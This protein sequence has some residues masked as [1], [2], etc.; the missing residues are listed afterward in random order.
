MT[1]DNEYLPPVNLLSDIQILERL[2]AEDPQCIFVS[3]LINPSVQVGPSSLDLRLGSK[4]EVPITI[5]STHIDLTL[6]KEEIR[7]QIDHYFVT[8]R[9]GSDGSFVLHPGEF[10]L[11]STLEVIRLP[12]DIAGRLEGRSSMGRLG[13]KIHAT[14][15]F[16]DPGFE[17]TLTFELTNAGKLPIKLFPGLRVGQLCFF[18]VKD[19][20]VSY[21]EKKQ[22]KYGSKLNV[23]RSR[24]YL[25]VEIGRK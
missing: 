5:N 25:D 12:R 17:G 20:Q 19:L 14:A 24:I 15:G 4:L 9:V 3:P 8:Q 2:V 7:H 11:A 16:V 1:E 6:S 22:N 13:L 10:A 18:P 23:E 21:I